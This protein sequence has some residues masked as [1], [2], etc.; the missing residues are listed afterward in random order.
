M[1][2]FICREIE[3]REAEKLAA[4]FGDYLLPYLQFGPGRATIAAFRDG[5]PAGFL[6]VGPEK[7][8]EP[9]SGLSD[10]M[11]HIIEVDKNCRRQGAATALLAAAEA[12]ARKEGYFQIRA[13]SSYDKKEAVPM[14]VRRGYAVCPAQSYSGRIHDYVDGF[15]AAKRLDA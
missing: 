9:L 7:F 3:E 11:I 1:E 2:A 12:F 4:V 13:W 14:W 5:R 6:A 10:A 8:G 15:Y